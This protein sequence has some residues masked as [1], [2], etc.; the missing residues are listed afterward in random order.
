MLKKKKKIKSQGVKYSTCVNKLSSYVVS[1]LH[2]NLPV[3]HQTA[4]QLLQERRD[5]FRSLQT[6]D[7]AVR[8]T[9]LLREKKQA[10]HSWLVCIYLFLKI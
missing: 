6:S 7:Q 1:I 3:W 5:V 9:T 10:T 4:E 2:R 8:I